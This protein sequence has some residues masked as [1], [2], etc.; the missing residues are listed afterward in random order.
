[1][2]RI[3]TYLSLLALVFCTSL[4][5][6]QRVPSTLIPRERV[7]STPLIYY[8]V[9][10]LPVYKLCSGRNS[11][12][13][14]RT[15]SS[16]VEADHC[17]RYAGGDMA[18]LATM[19]SL[20]I[21]AGIKMSEKWFRFINY[22]ILFD[23]ELNISEVRILDRFDIEDARY[24]DFVVNSL[25][26]LQGKW[27]KHQYSSRQWHLFRGEFSFFRYPVKEKQTW[28]SSSLKGVNQCPRSDFLRK[29]S[30]T[31]HR[32]LLVDHLR[33]E[34]QK[35]KIDSIVLMETL[36]DMNGAY[37][38]V[39]YNSRTKKL[40]RYEIDEVDEVDE[41]RLSKKNRQYEISAEECDEP[42]YNEYER[43]VVAAIQNGTIEAFVQLNN[44]PWTSPSFKC[45]ISLIRK[46]GAQYFFESY[47]TYYNPKYN[48]D[49]NPWWI[50]ECHM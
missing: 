32:A 18:L 49:L 1:M 13:Y 28:K 12:T 46:S 34:F 5:F 23:D 47:E 40:K 19:D 31:R 14:M 35:T 48:S 15:D 3:I 20:A 29:N 11:V 22:S 16:E 26:S 41:I 7:P 25:K 6:A 2:K 10:S 50:I 30:L 45:F 8:D 43:R 27:I 44:R 9:D 36:S 4:T 38:A 24:D 21:S 37:A 33:V 17:V 42:Y 39:V